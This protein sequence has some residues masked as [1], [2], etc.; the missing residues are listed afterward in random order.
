MSVRLLLLLSGAALAH[1]SA[2]VDL[3][4]GI[5]YVR[6]RSAAAAEISALQAARRPQVVDLR[7]ARA[8]AMEAAAFAAALSS[9][10]RTHPIVILVGP[11]TPPGML[12]ASLPRGSVT[13]GVATSQP[14]PMVVIAQDPADDARAFAALDDGQPL[15]ELIDGHWEKE[16]FDEASLVREFENGNTAPEPPLEPDPTAA[17]PKAPPPLRDRVLQRAGHI[18]QALA[19][20]RPPG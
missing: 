18:I 1:A 2:P 16:R 15:A 6:I 14:P 8:G 3:A 4:P 10:P 11:E 5:G 17:G 13:L 9:G 20:V 12:P 7:G 19:A